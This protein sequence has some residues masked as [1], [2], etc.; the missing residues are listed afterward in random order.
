MR[1]KLTLLICM[2]IL[3][4]LNA[5]EWKTI[6]K[7]DTYEYPPW[8]QFSINPYTNDI[9][10]L[11]TYEASV[12]ESDGSIELF[13]GMDLG[14]I[15]WYT[16]LAFT[17]QHTYISKAYGYGLHTFDE[18]NPQLVYTYDDYSGK[19]TTNGD[20]VFIIRALISG[21]HC[22]VKHTESGTIIRYDRAAPNLVVKNNYMYCSYSSGNIY[23][24][25]D[26]SSSS[27][28]SIQTDPHYLGGPFN[29]WK[30]TR[31][32]DTLYVG[33]KEGI[34]LAYA[35]DFFD[36]L[37]PNNTTGMLSPN[38][39]EIEFDHEDK[40]WAIF[41]DSSDEPIGIAK[42][43]GT[44]WIDYTANCPVDFSNF[45]GMEIDTLGNVWLA[46]NQALHTLLGPNSP[47][48]LSLVE[49][50]LALQVYPNPVSDLIHIDAENFAF[51]SLHDMNGREIQR[52]SEA[53][54]NIAALQS[55]VYLLHVHTNDGRVAK[56]KIVKE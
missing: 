1:I 27:L 28:I 48:W 26:N 54:L 40:L 13:Q 53:Q 12:I 56:R 44:N 55:G 52:T 6:N 19:V 23:Y 47:A 37:T 8:L 25:P 51:A 14:G 31:L 32:T 15:E 30:F 11:S 16:R 9:W 34:S 50:N 21:F 20:T 10:L 42:L 36:T 43:E 35:Y 3:F 5:Q 24:Y 49:N 4:K 7:T 38:V 2:M 33:G 39:L 45:L 41:G 29:D 18:Y 17:Q 46:D 22:L